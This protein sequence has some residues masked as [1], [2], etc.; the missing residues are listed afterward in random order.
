MS[1]GH[2]LKKKKTNNLNNLSRKWTRSMI[3]L[4]LDDPGTLKLF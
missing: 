1:L 2:K 3:S 4:D